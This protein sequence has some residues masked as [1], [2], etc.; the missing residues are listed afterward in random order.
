MTGDPE[1]EA[2]DPPVTAETGAAPRA[3]RWRLYALAI[4]T[5]L[6]GLLL[7]AFYA[8]EGRML[9]VPAP[10]AERLARSMYS[11]R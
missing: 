1:T 11:M 9:A 3:R 4:P 6:V 2:P 7:A 8:V 5:L 10:L